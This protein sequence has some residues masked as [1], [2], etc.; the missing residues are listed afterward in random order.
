MSI[1]KNVTKY[2]PP[3]YFWCDK[4]D[5]IVP[6]ENTKVMVEYLEKVGVIFSFEYFAQIGHRRELAIGTEE[7]SWSDIGFNF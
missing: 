6:Y 3:T 5:Q 7:E 1:E 2:F 4:E